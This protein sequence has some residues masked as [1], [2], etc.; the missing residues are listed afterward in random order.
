MMVSLAFQQVI[1]AENVITPEETVK[2]AEPVVVEKT[3][4][5]QDITDVTD[6]TNNVSSSDDS[7]SDVTSDVTE[8]PTTP[9]EQ[10][11]TE[12]PIAEEKNTSEVT[13][14]TTSIVPTTEEPVVENED[15][16]EGATSDEPTMSSAG[17]TALRCILF[18][19][20]KNALRAVMKLSYYDYTDKAEKSYLKAGKFSADNYLGHF[21]G[22]GVDVAAPYK[23]SHDVSGTQKA[24]EF[25]A[26][27]ISIVGKANKDSKVDANNE[28]YF[29]WNASLNSKAGVK[30]F[31]KALNRNKLFILPE[32]AKT[33]LKNDLVSMT[34]GML[35]GLTYDSSKPDWSASLDRAECGKA[36]VWGQIAMR[37]S[38]F[39]KDIIAYGLMTG[40]FPEF[41]ANFMNKSEANMELCENV[42][43][44]F[45]EDSMNQAYDYTEL[46]K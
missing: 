27:E 42:L 21:I 39:A 41:L 46:H 44:Q 36:F 35:E 34:T 4:D 9:A 11:T 38:N 5:A 45:I 19:A 24:A 32:A 15:T 33:V 14:P 3:D 31:F 7:N 12:Q 13:A 16:T 10:S 30:M 40:K 1:K 20:A 2:T 23:D 17:V 8:E 28:P 22:Y 6:A 26:K 25:F 43:A 29:K 18:F 37:A